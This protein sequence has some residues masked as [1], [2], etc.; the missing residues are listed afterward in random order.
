[1]AATRIIRLAN[2][3]QRAGFPVVGEGGPL[4]TAFARR[5]RSLAGGQHR[6]Q[7]LR[8]AHPDAGNRGR[9]G[10]PRRRGG[11]HRHHRLPAGFSLRPGRFFSNIGYL[12]SH[13][14]H[15]DNFFDRPLAYQAFLGNQY[16]DDGVQLRW[17]A[18]TDGLPGTRRRG[19]PRQT[20]IRVAARRTAASAPRRCSRTW[21]AMPACNN[22]WLAGVS[23]LSQ[24][25]DGEDGFSG[26]ANLYIADAPGSGR[27]TATSRMAAS[28]L[29]G[30]YLLDDRDGIYTVRRPRPDA[31]LKQRAVVGSGAAAIWKA[32][33]ASTAPGMSA[34]ATTSC[35]ATEP[36][37]SPPT[38]I[39]TATA[40]ADLAQQRVQPVPPAAQPRRAEC[41][42]QR[43]CA[44]PAIPGRPGRPWRA[45]D[46]DS[47]YARAMHRKCCSVFTMQARTVCAPLGRSPRRRRPS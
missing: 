27:R 33:I 34:I 43:Q 23:M 31:A 24:H 32:S 37:R 12:N 6:R 14:A 41:G 22:A 15:T 29:R 26:D 47:G 21:A 30:E 40:R 8:P 44:D 3:A 39:P 5:E 9:P 4:P 42:R 7:V 25:R 45:Q 10:P 18:P 38:S 2:A 1:M 11:L 36:A 17:V 28:P 46:S 19:V 35:G 16:G 20:S 13:H